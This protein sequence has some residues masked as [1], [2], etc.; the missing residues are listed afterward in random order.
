MVAILDAFTSGGGGG[1]GSTG[2]PDSTVRARNS[3][4]AV[5]TDAETTV[6]SLTVTGGF[7]F[8]LAQVI[9][10]GSADAE[11]IVY[12]D[13]AEVYR[14]RTSGADRAVELLH[15]N[16][17]PFAAGHVVTLKVIHEEPS[18]QNFYGTLLGRNE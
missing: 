9:A 15:G 4:M 13:S 16:A 14:T 8:K 5:A 17:I 7:T 2:M 6:V 11:W 18:V 1:G 10:T 3:A 12:D